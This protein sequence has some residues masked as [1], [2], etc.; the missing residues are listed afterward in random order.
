MYLAL[1]RVF[2][3]TTPTRN[4]RNTQLGKR[5]VV[6]KRRDKQKPLDVRVFV[7]VFTPLREL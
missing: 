1:V 4:K 3:H 2:L 7:L 6:V 5:E